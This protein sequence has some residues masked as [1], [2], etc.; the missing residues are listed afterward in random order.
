[1][2]RLAYLVCCAVSGGIVFAQEVSFEEHARRV[3][4]LILDGKMEAAIAEAVLAPPYPEN[5]QAMELLA[6]ARMA[7]GDTTPPVR[8]LI[9][10]ASEMERRAS[11]GADRL[12]LAKNSF[13]LGRFEYA[14]GSYPPALKRLEEAARVQEKL[15]APALDRAETATA[16]CDVLRAMDRYPRAIEQARLALALRDGVAGRNSALAGEAHFNIG[17]ALLYVQ[18]AEAWSELQIARELLERNLGTM[19]PLV[20]QVYLSMG[21]AEYHRARYSQALALYERA[22]AVMRQTLPPDHKRFL[23]LWNNYGL[24]LKQ[25]G[26][27]AKSREA[28]ENGLRI[29]EVKLGPEHPSTAQL[30]GNLGIVAMEMGD[31]PQALSLYGRALAIQEKRLGPDHQLVGAV[32]KSLGSLHSQ[33]TDYRQAEPEIFRAWQIYQKTFGSSNRKT[34]ELLRT[35]AQIAENLGR[36]EEARG[37]AVNA[38]ALAVETLGPDSVDTAN[39]YLILGHIQLQLGQGAPARASL[40]KAIAAF[41]RHPGEEPLQLVNALS[42]LGSLDTQ[43]SRYREAL[44][45]QVRAI[46]LAGKMAMSGATVSA[47][48][49]RE[50]NALIGLGRREEALAAALEGGRMRQDSIRQTARGMVERLA[51]SYTTRSEGGLEL[52]LRLMQTEEERRRVWDCVILGRNAVLDETAARS[53]NWRREADPRTGEAWRQLTAARTRLATLALQGS[54]DLDRARAE[55]EQQENALAQ[56]SAPFHSEQSRE[57]AGLKEVTAALSAHVGLLSFVAGDEY[58]AFT[59]NSGGVVRAFDLGPAKTI[60]PLV[61]AWREQIARERDSFGRNALA[62]ERS[63]RASA[64]A[65]RRAVWD[66]FAKEFAADRTVLLVADGRLHEINFAAL[67]SGKERYLAETGP[68]LHVLNAERDLTVVPAS[69]PGRAPELL[70]VGDPAFDKLPGT[71][72]ALLSRTFRGSRTGCAAFRSMRFPPLPASGAEVTEVA[73][74]GKQQGWRI[75]LLTGASASESALKGATHGQQVVHL[76]T[77]GFYLPGDCAEEGAANS[78]LLRAGLA[79]AGANLRQESTGAAEDGILTAQEA[80]SLDLDGTD[81]VVLSGCETGL[82]KVQSG[83]GVLGLRRAFQIAGASTQIAS[84]W[85]VLDEDAGHWMRDLYQGRFHRHLSTVESVA[86]ANRLAISRR[87][88]AH[89]GTHPFYWASFVASGS[90]R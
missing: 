57:R 76:A 44:A 84:L 72:P 78:P 26:D 50:A 23:A 85:P 63:Y 59:G 75:Q 22:L 6:E 40:E 45:L 31:Y 18:P 36:L 86:Y 30:L 19:H 69:T 64:A 62:N 51:L 70:A 55:T 46:G 79:L 49:V 71:V 8:D 82:G 56:K 42:D 41:D 77:H 13:L 10:R 83:E 24:C 21:T 58:W 32:L 60:E 5:A 9:S 90:W 43:E 47:L 65:L 27:Y 17:M 88:A 14:S 1:M 3:H 37:M 33:L 73:R 66:P 4:R 7:A 67:P 2:V 28:F 74:F 54:K 68:M 61:D 39:S 35:R 16:L 80:A 15:Q 20:A 89:A 12:A 29:A 53:R 11:A 81:W 25:S 48:R 38:L 34:L 52:A 87:R